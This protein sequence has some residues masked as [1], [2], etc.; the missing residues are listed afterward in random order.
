MEQASV[1]SGTM[2]M[3]YRHDPLAPGS[4]SGTTKHLADALSGVGWH[5]DGGALEV[6]PRAL[7]VSR[8]LYRRA[9]LGSEYARNPVLRRLRARKLTRRLHTS[10]A[11]VVLHIGTMHLPLRRNARDTRRHVMFI[12]TTWALWARYRSAGRPTPN[13]VRRQ[14]DSDER[15]AY[16]QVDHIFTVSQNAQ[17]NLVEEYGIA[18]DKVTAVGTGLGQVLPPAERPGPSATPRLLFVGKHRP[19]DKGLDLAVEA[20]RLVRRE[21]EGSTLTV[22]GA[23]PTSI[24]PVAGVDVKSWVSTDELAQ[25]YAGAD[26]FVL[27]ARNEPWGLVYLESLSQATPILGVDRHAFRELSCDGAFGIIV[28]EPDAEQVA[29]HIVAALA[30]RDA[31]AARGVAGQRHVAAW[32]DWT[33]V[34][35]TITETL[36]QM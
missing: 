29:S 33:R 13:W 8:A 19:F 15:R 31:L 11:S 26:L 6:G 25:L 10:D 16:R 17:R 21:Y 5:V 27:P 23:L 35:S 9:N 3:A 34:A 18:P 22:V 36:E 20:L 24:A 7:A 14:A 4:W 30:D 28:P 32:A 1:R 12:D 2:L